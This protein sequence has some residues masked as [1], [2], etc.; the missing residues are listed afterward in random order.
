MVSGRS[1]SPGR[2]ARR[3][4]RRHRLVL[5]ALHVSLSLCEK[6]GDDENEKSTLSI[7][8]PQA[9]SRRDM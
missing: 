4:A 3:L 2:K 9:T 6:V 1:N 7:P 5:H 8:F